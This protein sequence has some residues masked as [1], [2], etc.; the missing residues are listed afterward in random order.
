MP[1][2]IVNVRRQAIFSSDFPLAFA[3]DPAKTLL[4]SNIGMRLSILRKL[5]CK[6]GRLKKAD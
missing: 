5:R 6:N 2:E 1:R 3:G 4:A